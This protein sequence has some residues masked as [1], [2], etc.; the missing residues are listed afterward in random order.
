MIMGGTTMKYNFEQP[1]PD[2]LHYVVTHHPNQ[3]E[4]NDQVIATSHAPTEIITDIAAKGFDEAVIIGGGQINTLFLQAG[5]IDEA[6]ITITQ[7]YFGTGVPLFAGAPSVEFELL[8]SRPLGPSE[9]LMHY[10]VKK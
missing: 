6:W 5:L 10:A 2:R 1:L 3:F 7:Y 8:D 4:Q 9:M